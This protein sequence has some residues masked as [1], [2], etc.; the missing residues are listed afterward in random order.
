MKLTLD[1]PRRAG[2][3]GSRWPRSPGHTDRGRH[4]A[5]QRKPPAVN[6]IGDASCL[7]AIT[8]NAVMPSP[9][10]SIPPS[11]TRN[12]ERCALPA[13]GR[14]EPDYGCIVI[15]SMTIYAM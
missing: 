12:A 6:R 10:G 2:G 9:P 11:A 5:P 15:E 4:R 13:D 7:P 1:N 3:H 14:S 8:P